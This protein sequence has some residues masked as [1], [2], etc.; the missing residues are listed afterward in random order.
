MDT[1]KKHKIISWLNLFLLVINISAFTTIL[2]LN[3]QNNVIGNEN[4]KF[5]SDEFIR[6]ELKLNPRQFKEVSAM[7]NNVFRSYQLLLD[8]HCETNF[9]LLDELSSEHPSKVRLDSMANR[10]G[11][12]K[13]AIT[14]QTIRHFLNIRSICNPDQKIR[15]RKLLQEMLAVGKECRFCNKR[16][17]S[18]RDRL[19]K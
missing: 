15:L 2:F 8:M 12:I 19:L 4:K 14:R 17:C 3:K 16:E 5:S 10:I 9:D 7:D 11:K 13:G 6:K 18:R 1:S